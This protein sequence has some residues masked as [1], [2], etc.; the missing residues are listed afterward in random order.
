MSSIY[1]PDT[2]LLASLPLSRAAYS[3]RT[4]WILAAISWLAYGSLPGES[5]QSI[6]D[7][8]Q[9]I[10][11]AAKRNNTSQIRE[12]ILKVKCEGGSVDSD[13]QR[14]LEAVGFEFKAVFNRG[15]TQA[16][17]ALLQ[18]QQDRLP[19]LI[20]A[21]RGTQ[22]SSPQDVITDLDARLVPVAENGCLRGGRVHSGFAKAF[23]QVKDMIQ[24]VI[25]DDAY[26]Q[27]P[28]YITGHSL[29]GA[30]AVLATRYLT[31]Q[32][33]AATYTYGCPRVADDAFFEGMKTPVYRIV[34]AA[35]G[36]T[37]IPF[38]Y[39]TSILLRL[40]EMIPING[41]KSLS[42]W[43]RKN[44]LG[45]THYGD[46]TF[47]SD[48]AALLDADGIQFDGLQVV[49]GPDLIWRLSIV[50]KRLLVTGG[51]AFVEDHNIQI[52]AQKLYANA[53]RRLFS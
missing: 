32:K 4:A 47:L 20:L 42:E 11:A 31:H 2:N 5:D 33:L 12:L 1:F 37:T 28:F 44:F 23:R 41:T 9:E 40:I 8:I 19:M 26:S 16:F 38:G 13:V 10:E 7:L 45:Y 43:F 52:Y 53:R 36:V 39:A 29:G 34:N 21:F 50:W 3:D 35:D 30:L 14:E 51:K 25:A 6:D 49:H 48:A 15:G 24:D 27:Y 22:T 18:Q 17:L 46:L